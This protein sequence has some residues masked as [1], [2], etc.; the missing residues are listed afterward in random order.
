[1]K[2]WWAFLVLLLAGCHTTS[3][4]SP[5]AIDSDQLEDSLHTWM[6]Q[7]A[8]EGSSTDLYFNLGHA[9]YARGEAA[10]AVAFWRASHILTP[11][12]GDVSHNLAL[13]RTD[14]KGA[15]T[16]VEPLAPWTELLTPDELGMAGL[17]VVLV[18]F[19][20]VR[21]RRRPIGAVLILLGLLLGLR[22]GQIRAQE[23]GQPIAVVVADATY[24]REAPRLEARRIG[25][26]ETGTELRSIERQDAFVL[27]RGGE[28]LRGWIPRERLQIVRLR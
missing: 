22:A 25:S 3:V 18:G 4:V 8:Q 23:Y 11:R 6:E 17:L 21:A 9:Y 24:L 13:A 2:C 7:A 19:G 26:V 15:A 14:L 20:L 10:S 5:G 27:V 16:P 1:M 12:D 28:G